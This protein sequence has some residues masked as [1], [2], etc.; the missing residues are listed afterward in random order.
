MIGLR[1]RQ[2]RTR[3]VPGYCSIYVWGRIII[4]FTVYF[5]FCLNFILSPRNVDNPPPSPLGH[6]WVV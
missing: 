2:R 1:V 3:Q 5:S 4:A 6:P